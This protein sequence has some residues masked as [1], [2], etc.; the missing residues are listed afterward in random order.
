MNAVAVV[1]PI[2][3]NVAASSWSA[4]ESGVF[5]G[6]DLN[7]SDVNHVVNIVGYG[8]ENDHK[9]WLV[10]N[11]RSASWGINGYMFLA[12]SDD[13]D[14]V[15]GIDTTPQDGVACADQPEPQRLCGTCGSIHDSSYSVNLSYK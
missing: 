9:Y 8:V 12:R 2:A 15:C 5:S 10:R 4:Y 13:D 3:I 11:S 6:C 7:D 14:E 1:G